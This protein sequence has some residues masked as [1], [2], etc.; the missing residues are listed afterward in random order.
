[1]ASG[2]PSAFSFLLLLMADRS[3]AEIQFFCKA[4]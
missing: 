4:L 3:I 2:Q 1:L